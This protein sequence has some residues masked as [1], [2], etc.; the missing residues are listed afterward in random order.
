MRN[1]K[2]CPK[3]GAT[4]IVRIPISRGGGYNWIFLGMW[5]AVNAVGVTRYLCASCG[6]IE[7]WIDSADDI[8]KVKKRYST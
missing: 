1:S 7:E 4:D 8:A 5:G 6:Y 3:C 2:N